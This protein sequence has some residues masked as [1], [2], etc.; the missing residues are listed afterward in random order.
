MVRLNS[1]R[2]YMANSISAFLLY[3]SSDEAPLML[4]EDDERNANTSSQFGS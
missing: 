3:V 4:Y 2:K 1:V